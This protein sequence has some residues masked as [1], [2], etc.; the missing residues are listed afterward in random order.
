MKNMLLW[1][2]LVIVNSVGKWVEVTPIEQEFGN[3]MSYILLL[4]AILLNHSLNQNRA[5]FFYQKHIVFLKTPYLKGEQLHLGI[6]LL[7]EPKEA[8]LCVLIQMSNVF[9]RA[10][11]TGF[12]FTTVKSKL[13]F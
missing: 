13:T 9:I 12:S 6:P 2:L 11:M 3:L 10:C 5:E 4:L 8:N 7:K 1:K